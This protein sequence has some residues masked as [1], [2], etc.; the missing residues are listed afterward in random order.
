MVDCL[1]RGF[2]FYHARLGSVLAHALARDLLWR[3]GQAATA[4]RRVVRILS[5]SSGVEICRVVMSLLLPAQGTPLVLATA[6]LSHAQHHVLVVSHTL[7][8][9]GWIKLVFARQ[10]KSDVVAFGEWNAR[11]VMQE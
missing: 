9:R 11:P 1:V 10:L 3:I 2:V 7:P 6:L 4:A 8:R 5:R